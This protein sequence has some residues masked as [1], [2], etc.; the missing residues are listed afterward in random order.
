MNDFMLDFARLARKHF[1][2]RRAMAK[3][4]HR[5]PKQP[6][7]RNCCAGCVTGGGECNVALSDLNERGQC[8]KRCPEWPGAALVFLSMAPLTWMLLVE[9]W[10]L[11]RCVVAAGT[12][13]GLGFLWFCVAPGIFSFVRRVRKRD[14]K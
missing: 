6:L 8:L 4:L 13:L 14:G 12:L 10:I 7:A 5:A 9:G 11:L 1:R 3:E 2:A